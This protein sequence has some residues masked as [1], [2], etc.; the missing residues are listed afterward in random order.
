MRQEFAVVDD[1]EGSRRGL[2]RGLGE[3]TA[4]RGDWV[5]SNHSMSKW[6]PPTGAGDSGLPGALGSASGSTMLK[7]LSPGSG[8]GAG[9]SGSCCAVTGRSLA[10]VTHI[11]GREGAFLQWRYLP[12][13][14]VAA[15][16]VNVAIALAH[17]EQ[18][19]RLAEELLGDFGDGRRV[20]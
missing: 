20:H 8:R 2:G 18:V 4:L 13:G 11:I 19:G 3:E 10:V 9:L 5:S 12:R 6:A 7:G 16:T 14:S 17:F 15:V 1:L